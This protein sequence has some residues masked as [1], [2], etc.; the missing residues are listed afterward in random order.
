[1]SAWGIGRHAA[2]PE[3]AKVDSPLEAP[4]PP[5]DAPPA[6]EEPMDGNGGD[7]AR[8]GDGGDGGNGD[9][10]GRDRLQTFIGTP[11]KWIPAE[12]VTLFTASIAAF[13]TVQDDPAWPLFIIFIV[14]TPIAV[15]GGAFAQSG[16][17][18]VTQKVLLAA[19]LSVPA[20]AIWS[21]VVPN[22]GWEDIDW[23]ADNPVWTTV[24]AAVAGYIYSL[25]AE[26]VTRSA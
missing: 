6:D 7:G 19:V 21:F 13:V 4:K 23:V 20:F 5:A 22:S 24:I 18:G 9:G 12:V 1:M 14:L 10:E 8:G 3:L 15:I 25:F 26:G 2:Q 17:S 16:L 11:I